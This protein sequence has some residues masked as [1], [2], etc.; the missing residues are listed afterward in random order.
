MGGCAR[1]K[2]FFSLLYGVSEDTKQQNLLLRLSSY[3]FSTPHIYRES[4]KVNIFR[5]QLIQNRFLE[6]KYRDIIS[7]DELHTKIIINLIF[8]CSLY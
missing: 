2:I 1:I 5:P 3:V 4:T 8:R 7:F 6:Y